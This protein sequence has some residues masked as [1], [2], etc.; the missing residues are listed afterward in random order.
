MKGWKS[1]TSSFRRG[2]GLWGLR[3]R[4]G[5]RLGE[6]GRGGGRP[7]RAGG[8]GGGGGG[9]SRRSL[10]RR[11]GGHGGGDWF[12]RGRLGC[13][14]DRGCLGFFLR[15][16]ALCGEP[17][18]DFGGLGRMDAVKIGVGLRELFAI[19]QQRVEPIA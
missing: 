12:R 15:G 6:G 1:W 18:V 11:S 8:R 5:G 10:R 14:R 17:R 2:R 7:P 3:A 19:Q 13:G 9:R 16:L 4:R